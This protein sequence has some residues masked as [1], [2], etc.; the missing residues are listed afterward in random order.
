MALRHQHTLHLAQDL[1]RIRGKL[2]HVRQH[3]QVDAVAGEGQMLGI[4]VD[5]RRTANATPEAEGNPAGAQILDVRQPDLQRVEA[6]D[7]GRHLI[8]A[9]LFPVQHV[10]ALRRF[11]P[12]GKFAV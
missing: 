5:L 10:T 3:D 6:E 11:Q 4:G 7:V 2:Q 1:V 9:R 8:D 12:G